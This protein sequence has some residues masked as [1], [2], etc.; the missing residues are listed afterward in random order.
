MHRK[1]ELTLEEFGKPP[2]R[3][4]NTPLSMNTLEC[5]PVGYSP[6]PVAEL[7]AVLRKEIRKLLCA[8]ATFMIVGAG[9]ATV[10]RAIDAPN[11]HAEE[12]V[13]QPAVGWEREVRKATVDD[14]GGEQ[15]E[16][17]APLQ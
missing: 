14:S 16:Q 17:H 15:R 4:H 12:R 3:I 7:P 9:V 13:G 11:V 1:D 8:E 5:L 6:A 2:E 10:F